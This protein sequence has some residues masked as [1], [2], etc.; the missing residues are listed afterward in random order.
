[1]LTSLHVSFC[2]FIVVHKD[3]TVMQFSAPLS[4]IRP[5]SSTPDPA[6]RTYV[7]HFA[8]SLNGS[9]VALGGEY[10]CSFCQSYVL[11]VEGNVQRDITYSHLNIQF[12]HHPQ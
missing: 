1:M 12:P 11:G 4:K 6:S 7:G 9:F 3:G 8:C 5:F 2:Q 10:A